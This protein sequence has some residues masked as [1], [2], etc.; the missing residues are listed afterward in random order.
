MNKLK[1]L[2]REHLHHSHL[3][4]SNA[5][6]VMD[7][8]FFAIENNLKIK[9]KAN[10]FFFY[11]KYDK[12]LIGDARKVFDIH[13]K[14]TPKDDLQVF[15]LSFNFIT[16]EAQNAILKMLEEPKD[17][18]HFFIIAP[19]KNMFLETIISRVAIIDLSSEQTSS[20]D[21]ARVFM[22][23]KIGDRMKTIATLIKDIRDDKKTKQDV[24]NLLSGLEIELERKRDFEALRQVLEAKKYINL[25]GASLKILLE[26]VALNV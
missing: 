2:N 10:E 15:V 16:R 11:E 17:R 7:D 13:L 23:K 22:K 19:S 24:V 3:I 21:N 6:D 1:S 5:D 9:T 8:V 14:K 18:T 12:F 20:L 4:I 25:S 26:N